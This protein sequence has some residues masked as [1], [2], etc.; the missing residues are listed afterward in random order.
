MKYNV[1][2]SFFAALIVA[3]IVLGSCKQNSREKVSEDLFYFPEKN[4]YFDSRTSTYFYSL[5]NAASWD[6][7]IYKNG[8]AGAV[9][10]NRIAV[11]RPAG[12]IWS[13]NDSH[14]N[15]YN[16]T[17]LNLVNH[18]TMLL[19]REDS[20]KRSK[21]IIVAVKPKAEAPKEVVAEEPPKKGLKKFFNKLFGK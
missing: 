2:L 1:S 8:D 20:L 15:A 4:V 21:P 11:A 6:S 10:G 12:R 19:A 5:D 17:L 3:V 9:L 16:G 13:N 7:L 18:R 14:R